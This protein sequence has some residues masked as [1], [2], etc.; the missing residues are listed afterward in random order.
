VLTDKRD[1]RC[2]LERVRASGLLWVVK[3]RQSASVLIVGC[4][5]AAATTGALIAMGRRLG[6]AAFP[7]ASI[8]AIVLHSSGFAIE[9]RSLVGGVLLHIVF[10]FLWSAL[11]VQLSRGFG[12]TFSAALTATTEFVV[13]WLIAWWSGTGLASALALGDRLVYS[14][15]LAMALVVGMR[16][17]FSLGR[18]TSS[19]VGAM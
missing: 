11:A 17:A 18:N 14:V 16:F 4:L 5:V 19:H 1:V 7:F 6:S 12:P 2:T 15:V 10:S 3:E 8:S 9:S 13:S